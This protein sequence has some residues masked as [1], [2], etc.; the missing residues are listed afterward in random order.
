MPAI[1]ISVCDR[2]SLIRVEMRACPLKGEKL[3]VATLPKGLAGARSN[4][5]FTRS[6]S[7]M[8]LSVRSSMGTVKPS[9]TTSSMLIETRPGAT[10]APWEKADILSSTSISA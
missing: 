2:A 8:T 3:C 7:V 4:M 6:S 10:G 5:A 9:A 1:A